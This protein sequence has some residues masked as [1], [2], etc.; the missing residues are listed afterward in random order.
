MV[1][2]WAKC[3]DIANPYAT[4]MSG[5]WTWYVLKAYKTRE[6]ELGDTYARWFCAVE[7]PHTGKYADYGDVYIATIPSTPELERLLNER[8]KAEKASVK[9]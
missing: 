2:L 4:I 1:N 3:R 8:L 5:D 9:C 6:A 7:S